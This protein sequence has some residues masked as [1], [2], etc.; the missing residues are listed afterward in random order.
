VAK[1]D[2]RLIE[3]EWFDLRDVTA[4]VIALDPTRLINHES[5]AGG[6]PNQGGNPFDVGGGLSRIDS[7]VA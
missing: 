5:G 6:G 2:F 3:N 7:N 4:K 1:G